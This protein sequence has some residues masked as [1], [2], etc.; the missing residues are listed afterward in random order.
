MSHN[1]PNFCFL[2]FWAPHHHCVVQLL[3]SALNYDHLTPN[4]QE[5]SHLLTGRQILALFSSLCWTAPLHALET[6]N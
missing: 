2:Y 5:I 1:L 6:E 3:V 4:I